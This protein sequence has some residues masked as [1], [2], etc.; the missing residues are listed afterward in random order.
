MSQ[1]LF[2][3][4]LPPFSFPSATQV[5]EPAAANSSAIVDVPRAPA[6]R[7]APRWLN[8][9]FD[10][11]GILCSCQE[12]RFRDPKLRFNNDRATHS[13]TVP[14]H[15][16][17][18]LVWVRPGCNAFLD[19]LSKFASISV[20]S[21]MKLG[22]T[23]TIAHY[24][25]GSVTPPKVVYG[26]EHCKRVVT[27]VSNRVSRFLKVKGTEKDVFLKTLSVGLFSKYGESFTLENT[28]I[29]DDS[30][31][32]HVLNNPENVLL[33]DTWSPVGAGA[34]DTFLLGVLLPWLQ[35]LHSSADLGLRIFRRQNPLGLPLLGSDPNNLDYIE[36]TRAIHLSNDLQRQ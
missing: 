11:N 27:E 15:V 20:W 25:F 6:R 1:I 26:Q 31:Y 7:S 21:S 3:N 19:A 2:S 24:L 28:I 12:F 18:K 9:V 35:R 36:L 10:L 29:V 17:P 34:N 4:A 8:I 32:K 33:A 14:A 23:S 13:S 16:G 5:V 22:T 30:A